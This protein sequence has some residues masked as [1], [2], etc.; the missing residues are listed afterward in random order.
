[1]VAPG[2]AVQ[3]VLSYD[4]GQSTFQT[5]LTA[6]VLITTSGR[7]ASKAC[8]VALIQLHTFPV[9]CSAKLHHLVLLHH[10]FISALMQAPAFGVELLHTLS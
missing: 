8:C 10:L 9:A 5:V 6:T 4:I 3:V 7:P 2:Q 1:M